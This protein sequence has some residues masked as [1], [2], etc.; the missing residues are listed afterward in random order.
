MKQGLFSSDKKKS[1]CLSLFLFLTSMSPTISDIGVDLLSKGRE[2]SENTCTTKR[3][4]KNRS[5]A[6]N[7]KIKKKQEKKTH[8]K[9]KE[10]NTNEERVCGAVIICSND[11]RRGRSVGFES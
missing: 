1:R 9:N 4:R 5:H 8:R 11:A 2:N 3:L 10:R 6:P 7:I